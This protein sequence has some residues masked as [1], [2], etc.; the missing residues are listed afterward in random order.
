MLW[1]Y[2]CQRK[3]KAL[4]ER[5][6]TVSTTLKKIVSENVFG[7]S[8]AVMTAAK[9]FFVCRKIFQFVQTKYI[10]TLSS[11][12]EKKVSFAINFSNPLFVLDA[13]LCPWLPAES[14]IWTLCGLLLFSFA[15][16]VCLHLL[17][18]LQVSYVFLPLLTSINVLYKF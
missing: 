6:T 1:R 16:K 7:T 18:L 3:S 5:L 15:E 14:F 10:N 11:D 4:F 12:I 2:Y 9:E 8:D 13:Q 17:Y